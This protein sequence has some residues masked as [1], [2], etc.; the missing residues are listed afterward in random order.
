MKSL[1]PSM[2]LNSRERRR[3]EAEKHNAQ[4]TERLARLMP[5]VVDPQP[6]PALAVAPVKPKLTKHGYT[7][8]A[9]VGA[10]LALSMALLAKTVSMPS[11]FKGHVP[12]HYGRRAK[13]R[14]AGF[15]HHKHMIAEQNLARLK[16]ETEAQKPVETPEQK[17]LREATLAELEAANALP[18]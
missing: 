7:L 1:E 13:A 17:S 8:P 14:A 11:R 18:A 3:L 12:S 16:A 9:K 5:V 6:E 4:R 2:F 10:V 15:M